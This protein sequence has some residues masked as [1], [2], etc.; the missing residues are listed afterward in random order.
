MENR[1]QNVAGLVNKLPYA[2]R[3]M[4]KKMNLRGRPLA[5]GKLY[6]YQAGT[7]TPTDAW[8]D[9]GFSIKNTNPTFS[10][11]VGREHPA[12]AYYCEPSSVDRQLAVYVQVRNNT[13]HPVVRKNCEHEW[14]RRRWLCHSNDR[15]CFSIL[16]FVQKPRR[17]ASGNYYTQCPSC[18]QAQ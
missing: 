11:G 16:D 8:Q 6:V 18:A 15:K 10:M 9:S 14:Q 7:T 1:L 17:Q 12:F 13:G 2:S 5:G 3:P 4:L